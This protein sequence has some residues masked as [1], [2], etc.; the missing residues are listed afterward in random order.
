[1]IVCGGKWKINIDDS[2]NHALTSPHKH[3]PN[4]S[5]V[6]SV[7]FFVDVARRSLAKECWIQPKTEYQVVECESGTKGIL[8]KYILN[9][10]H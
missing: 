9:A 8:R 1:M 7:L 10:Q 3:K 5:F 4:M 6:F 2:A